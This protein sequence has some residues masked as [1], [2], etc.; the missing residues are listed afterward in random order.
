MWRRLKSGWTR[1]WFGLGSVAAGL[2]WVV[3]VKM[4]AVGFVCL[5]VAWGKSPVG[6]FSSCFWLWDVDDCPR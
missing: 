2:F 1:P 6:L 5:G 3:R 4:R